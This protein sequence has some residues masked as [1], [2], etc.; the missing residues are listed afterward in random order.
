MGSIHGTVVDPSGAAVPDASVV[1][2][3]VATGVATEVKASQ[4]GSF[5]F[6]A[7][8]IGEYTLKVS[9][10]G[11]KTAV[12]T[13]LRVVTGET[14]TVTVPLELGAVNQTVQVTGT[15]SLVDYTRTT[16]GSTQLSAT[17]SGLPINQGGA[18]RHARDFLGRTVS[19]DR[20]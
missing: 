11:F 18:T 13:G 14:V 2:Q 9:A 20:G 8:E 7:L 1:A 4:T 6:P 17:L 16:S 10:G 5:I 12:Q 15:A 19:R 3:R